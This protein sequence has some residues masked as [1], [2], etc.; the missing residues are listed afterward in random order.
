[1]KPKN[2]IIFLTLLMVLLSTQIMAAPVGS[3][4]SYQGQLQFDD[5]P[6]TGTYDFKV[7][8]WNQASGGSF[9]GSA[10]E[11]EDVDVAAGI[12]TM[13]LDFTD[14]PFTGDDWFLKIQVRE[15]LSVG[16]YTALFPKQRINATPYAIQA[17]YLAA[18]GASNG[19][20]LKF[21]GSNWVA[22]TD[23]NDTSPWQSVN[24]GTRF[25]DGNVA[26]GNSINAAGSTLLLLDSQAGDSPLR[27]KVNGSTKMRIFDNGGTSV[28]G[29]SIPEIN[30]LTVQG[31]IIANS[32]VEIGNVTSTGNVSADLIVSGVKPFVA[33]VNG[34]TKLI[35]SGSGGTG[36]GGAIEGDIP[37]NGLLVN[38]E[39]KTNG[40]INVGGK[41]KQ[42]INSHGF[43]KAG[44][45]FTC[46]T[47]PP[48]VLNSFNNVNTGVVLVQ[49][50]VPSYLGYCTLIFPFNVSNLFIQTYADP[51]D[52]LYAKHTICR[53]KDGSTTQI[54]CRIG[55]PTTSDE[56]GI[57]SI[58]LF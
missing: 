5:V 56:N 46:G 7:E 35:V 51:T 20:V 39:L 47:A 15:G 37:D 31:E 38:G 55:N 58:L 10:L 41:P 45:K 53:K 50:H 18:N 4:F 3:Q 19:Q 9:F 49:N 24:G 8:L 36:I 13:E 43:A 23:D 42:D 54:D 27:A 26:I 1:M 30:G 21:N 33:Q 16:S 44:I 12:F 11:I 32:R 2:K 14:V 25:I 52:N 17:D 40:D 34:S 6:V 48:I 57:A 29:N 22:G 28:G